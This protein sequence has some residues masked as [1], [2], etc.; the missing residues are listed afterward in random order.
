MNQNNHNIYGYKAI[1]YM[2]FFLV[3]NSHTHIK[4][5]IGQ[6]VGTYS[7]YSWDWKFELFYMHCESWFSLKYFKIILIDIYHG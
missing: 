3:P 5:F 1:I 6:V 7:S 2:P 4:L